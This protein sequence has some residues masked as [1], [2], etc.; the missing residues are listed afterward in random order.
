MKSNSF[1]LSSVELKNWK[2]FTDRTFDFRE[3]GL[4]GI[5]GS[6]GSGKSSIVDAIVW[7]LYGSR[8]KDVKKDELR[9]DQMDYSKEITL[10]RVTFTYAGQTIEAFRQMKGKGHT[11]S[12]GLFVDGKETVIATGGTVESWVTN[13]I[14][15]DAKGFTTAIIVPQKQLDQLVDERPENQRKH[16]ERLAG[17]EEMNDA[18]QKA[19]E[20]AN[21]LDKELKL[22]PGSETDVDAAVAYYDTLVAKLKRLESRL[23]TLSTNESN[24]KITLDKAIASFRE[25]KDIFDKSSRIKNQ[26][27]IAS[28]KLESTESQLS[29][30]EL[31]VKDLEDS[32]GEIDFEKRA[33]LQAEYRTVTQQMTAASSEFAAKEANRKSIINDIASADRDIENSRVTKEQA[34]AKLE[35]AVKLSKTMESLSTLNDKHKASNERQHGVQADL[36]RIKGSISELTE[37]IGTLEAALG[38]LTHSATCPTCHQG[39]EDPSGL[40][41]NF[42][43]TLENLKNDEISKKQELTACHEEIEDIRRQ[44]QSLNEVETY[45][46]NAR[47]T[48]ERMNNAHDE[49]SRKANELQERLSN[50]GE[51]NADAHAESLNA[52]E[53]R[54]TEIVQEGELL[55]QAIKDLER[56]NGNKQELEK[57]QNVKNEQESEVNNLF[58]LLKSFGDID[59]LEESM[60]F[61]DNQV[62]ELRASH[63]GSFSEMK[64]AETERASLSAQVESAEHIMHMEE[65]N[66]NKKVAKLA[67]LEEKTAIVDLLVEY[68]KE[69]VARIAPELSTAASELISSMTNGKFIEVIVADD[70]KTD[71]IKDNGQ[72]YS[73][74][75]LSGGEKSVVALALRIA[76]SSLISND[77]AGLLWLDEALPA[78]DSERRTAI[79]NVLRSVPIQ[80]IVMINHTHEAEDIVDEV[81]RIT[82]NGA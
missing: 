9:N 24:A 55:S 60:A 43:R 68:R 59:D 71:V 47:S 18:V 11:V 75:Q 53:S 78:Q 51:A 54:R 81:I 77:D 27:V 1:V 25:S 33:E 69:R 52:L 48:L 82:P 12:A 21:E 67:L 65:T 45:I 73:I 76:I 29:N 36:G 22:L 37:S 42:K 64:N 20:I 10:V 32:I 70:F 14:G 80:Q 49:L 62:E 57:L 79:L 39:L 26:W 2:T 16:I 41:N 4:T 6:N 56:L 58:E 17:I 7:C 15:M 44:I 66:F 74:A 30:F 8:P 61:Q 38:D 35:D 3:E 40:L 13:R 46:N 50:L 5:V 72:V 23:E 31:A 28:N 19:R 34:E 63:N